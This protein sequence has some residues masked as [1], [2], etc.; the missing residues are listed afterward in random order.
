MAVRKE[1]ITDEWTAFTDAG[2]SGTCWLQK[3]P[4]RG[5]VVISHSDSGTGALNDNISYPA[6]EL[7]PKITG[8]PADNAGDIYYAKCRETG[9][10]AVIISD[11]V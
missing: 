10:E 7:A 1:T 3:K 4:S 5:H 11:V 8:I 2:E 6:V 9:E